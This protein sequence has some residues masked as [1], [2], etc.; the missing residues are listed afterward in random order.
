MTGEGHDL[1][2]GDVLQRSTTSRNPGCGRVY[3]LFFLNV[4]SV[5]FDFK[6]YFGVG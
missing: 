3:G 6:F 2:G 4:K 5:I 1:V